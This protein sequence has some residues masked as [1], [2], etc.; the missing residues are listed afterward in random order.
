MQF[1]L[2][3]HLYDQC[4]FTLRRVVNRQGAKPRR[5]IIIQIFTNAN[6][7]CVFRIGRLES[8]H[9]GERTAI[10][11]DQPLSGDDL[12]DDD[13]CAAGATQSVNSRS[14]K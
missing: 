1:P 7:I 4:C 10:V 3:A 11:R 9:H 13:S 2:I 14:V 12:R 6:G 5:E 8:L